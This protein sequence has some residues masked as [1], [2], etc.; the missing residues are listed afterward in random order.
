MVGRRRNP[1][2]LVYG[3]PRRNP[4]LVV[5]GNPLPVHGRERLIGMAEELRYGWDGEWWKHPFETAVRILGV[6]GPRRE[7][8]ILLVGVDGQPL[9][10]T[11]AEVERGEVVT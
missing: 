8:R 2:L 11:D 4:S 9:W 7:R 3:N 10:A 1:A 6:L 5:Y